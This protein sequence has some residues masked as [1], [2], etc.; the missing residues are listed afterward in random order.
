MENDFFENIEIFRFK[1]PEHCCTRFSEAVLKGEIL[2]AYKEFDDIDETAWF[3]ESKWHIYFCPFCG[4]NV[5][6][7]GFGSYHKANT[8]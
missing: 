4:T 7:I 3:V 5:R 2:Y 6:G 8:F 1:E